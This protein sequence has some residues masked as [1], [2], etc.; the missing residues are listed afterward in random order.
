MR[1]ISISTDKKYNIHI[2]KNWLLQI[3]E[4]ILALFPVQKIL[5]VIDENV[6][7]IYS[8]QLNVLFSQKR[9]EKYTLPSGEKSKN[10]NEYASILTDLSR[11]NFTR[12][13]LILA[14]GGGVVGDI[15]G[16]VA[17]T[18][19][20]GIDYIQIPTTLLSMIDSSIGGKT[21][22][23]FNSK[24]NIVGSFYSPKKVYID[25]QFLDSLPE[26]EILSGNGELTK[27]AIL[28]KKIYHLVEKNVSIDKVIVACLNYKR[29]IVE[30][31]FK[32]S[33]I[34][35]LLNL[36]HTIGHAIEAKSKF[37]IKHGAAVALG[38]IKSCKV[39]KQ[40]KLLSEKEEK[41]IFELLSKY[42][43]Y[44]NK[45]FDVFE[46]IVSDKK[47]ENLDRINFVAIKRI[48]K[49]KVISL[50]LDKLK[51]LM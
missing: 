47:M 30:K 8:E 4:E 3:Q 37:K 45:E 24:K 32:E 31:D 48:G 25:T 50:T 29:K 1:K 33:N 36:G 26:E 46:Y 10:I 22:I 35:M 21:A 38:I 28:D 23:D 42:N 20:R 11:Y 27:Y 16:F 41:R 6:D 9:V 7:K 39:S 43:L 2:G 34:R 12:K 15:T 44:S 13:D 5:V 49:C 19:L 40:L 18:Y 17:S 14:L 51:K